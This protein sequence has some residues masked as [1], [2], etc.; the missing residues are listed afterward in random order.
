PPPP[1]LPRPARHNLAGPI[2]TTSLSDKQHDYFKVTRTSH[3]TYSL[4][5]TTDPTPLYRIEVDPSPTADPAIQLFD[6][7]DPFPLAAARMH[8]FVTTA[9]AICTREPAGDNAKWHAFNET[10]AVL[11]VEPV[12]GLQTVERNVSW[13]YAKLSEHLTCTLMGS[14]FGYSEENM[15]LGRYGIT[16]PKF[17]ADMV[18]EVMRGGGIEMELGIVVQAFARL[19]SD[20]RRSLKKWKHKK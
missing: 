15:V 13:T 17:S 2:Q 16:G 12:P 11:V 6:F 19:E 20:R 18:F 9:A 4:A 10:F 14:L 8:P 1:P 5:L 7:T 3:T